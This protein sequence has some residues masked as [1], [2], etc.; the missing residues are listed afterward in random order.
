MF[1][2]KCS[3]GTIFIDYE[4]ISIK[5]D[6]HISF[7]AMPGLLLFLQKC[8]KLVITLGIFAVF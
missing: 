4:Y 2:M 8:S 6:D 5:F 1:E 3:A 7:V